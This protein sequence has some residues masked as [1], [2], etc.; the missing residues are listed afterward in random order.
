MRLISKDD[1]ARNLRKLRKKYEEADSVVIQ[2]KVQ[3]LNN[4]YLD[5]LNTCN[6]LKNLIFAYRREIEIAAGSAN[7]KKSK[8]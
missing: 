7:K 5:Y 4:I 6:E 2:E 8:V 3:E 1:H